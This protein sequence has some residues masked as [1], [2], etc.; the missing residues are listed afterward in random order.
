MLCFALGV[1]NVLLTTPLWVVNTRLKLQGA[2]FRNEDI[3]PTN[4]KGIIG[5]HLVLSST[6][7][8]FMKLNMSRT[9]KFGETY[10][11][12]GFHPGIS[13]LPYHFAVIEFYRKLDLAISDGN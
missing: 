3:V 8:K 6:K 10:S 11:C 12:N 5:K 13:V 9:L 1:V 2:K 7:E 4:Y